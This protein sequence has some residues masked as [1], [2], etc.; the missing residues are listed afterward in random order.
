MGGII[1]PM[2]RSKRYVIAAVLVVLC[3]IVSGCG[4]RK[5]EET[6]GPAAGEGRRIDMDSGEFF[7]SPSEITVK[8]GETVTIALKNSGSVEHNISIDEFNIDRDY[9]PGQTIMVTFT[10]DRTGTFRIY[11]DIVGHSE[12]GMVGTLIVQ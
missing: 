4:G 6:P 10:P 1:K 2:N 11:C 9:N 3:V 7:F 12:A 8:R 5:Q